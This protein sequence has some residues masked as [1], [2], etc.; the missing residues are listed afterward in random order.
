M[1][2]RV[3][4]MSTYKVKAAEQFALNLLLD[5]YKERKAALKE[6]VEVIQA[7]MDKQTVRNRRTGR[8]WQVRHVRPTLRVD[9]F[10]MKPYEL[11]VIDI[12]SLEIVEPTEDGDP[13]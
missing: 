5:E 9:V 7:L 1:G 3:E 11:G 10:N 12:R 13:R 6:T 4:A 8:T 2:G